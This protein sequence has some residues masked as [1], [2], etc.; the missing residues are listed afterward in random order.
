[1]FL[2]F[3]YLMNFRRS[4]GRLLGSVLFSL[5]LSSQRLLKNAEVF[6]MAD[7]SWKNDILHCQ[8]PLATPGVFILDS[9]PSDKM[10]CMGMIARFETLVSAP[11]TMFQFGDCAGVAK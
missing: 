2:A 11:K 3:F 6:F 8:L 10:S 1:M 7:S 5:P 9:D 4:G